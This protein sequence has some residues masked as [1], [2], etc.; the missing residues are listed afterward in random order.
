MVLF[1]TCVAACRRSAGVLAIVGGRPIRLEVAADAIT[2]QTGKPLAEVSPEL[3]ATLFEELIEEEVILAASLDPRDRELTGAAR[4]ARVR[5]LSA[6][7]CPPP[8]PPTGEEVGAYLD[9][10]AELRSAGE[11][12]LLRQLVLADQASARAAQERARHGEDF[13]ALSREL[14][15]AP[16]AATGGAIGWVERGQ[17]PPEFEAA[18]F[19][20][21]AGAVS[22]PVASS[23]GWHVFQ[24]VERRR[25]GAPDESVIA[26][27]RAM[28]AAERSER[29]GREC[30]RALARRVGVE[31]RAGGGLPFPCRNPFEE[32]P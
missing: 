10:H 30:L 5:E 3:A 13:A 27:A 9:R 24:V 19:G 15:R 12:V 8:P 18:V 29:A 25:G 23:A 32:T 20:L 28:L 6:S 31:V 1:L 22:A 17:L 16:N 14:S 7:L 26:S 4:M 2:S 11:R 21:P